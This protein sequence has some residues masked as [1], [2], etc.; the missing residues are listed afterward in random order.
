MGKYKSSKQ[1][2]I[3]SVILL[4]NF[5]LLQAQP[6]QKLI[7]ITVAPDHTDWN[8]KIGETTKFQITITKNSELLP[9]TVVHYEVGPEMMTP[10]KSDSVNLKDGKMLIDG[11]TMKVPGFLRCVVTA[12]VDGIKYEAVAT[13]GYNREMILP[14]TDAPADFNQFWDKAKADA[15]KIPMDAQLTI[16]PERCTEK[17]NV[18]QASFQ[19]CKEGSRFY[20]ILCVP[21]KE[22]KYPALLEVP[23]AGVRPYYGDVAMAENG[24]ITFE[25]GI[26]GI[27]VIQPPSIYTDLFRTTLMGYWYFNLDDKDRYYYKRVYLGCVRS[28]D[29]IF[30]LPQF[31]GKTLAVTGGSQG[32]GLSIVT[33]SLDSRVKYLGAFFPALCD[34]TGDLYGRAGGWPQ[35]FGKDD[36]LFNEKK[37]KIETSKYYDAVN[38]ARNI[39]VPGYFSWGYNDDTCPPT[40]MYAAY[41]VITAPKSLFVVQETGHWQYPEQRE[42]MSKWLLQHLTGDK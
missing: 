23:G 35:L 14:T 32:G 29:F 17:V 11:G 26:H 7:K 41:N 15:A 34:F 19:N 21:K 2:I 25:V 18:Y 24:V 9:N 10:V 37:D 36:R 20:G 16:L 27:S 38:F 39:K 12:W 31:D 6:L 8:Y 4:L 5:C 40:S 1:R 22:G 33:A 3:F 28:I 30:S 42:K 13:T